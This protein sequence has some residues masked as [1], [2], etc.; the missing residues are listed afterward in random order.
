MSRQGGIERNY[1]AARVLIAE[2]SAVLLPRR[3]AEL[4]SQIDGL[5]MGF[6]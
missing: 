4:R 6:K 2:L 3:R 5:P 1:A